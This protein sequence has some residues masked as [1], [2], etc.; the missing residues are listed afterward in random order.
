MNEKND[1]HEK[2]TPLVP[3][4]DFAY[5]QALARRHMEEEAACAQALHDD[6]DARKKAAREEAAA[7]QK[8]LA[9]EKI[10]LMKLKQGVIEEDEAE[11][12]REAP[13]EPLKKMNKRQ[14]LA[15]FWYHHKVITLVI[16]LFGGLIGY[17]V[18]DTA[19]KVEPDLKI[20]VTTDNGLGLRLDDLEAFFTPYATD[21]NGDGKVVV[22]A[23]N[24]P[25]NPRL[26]ANTYQTNS[27]KLS[28]LIMSGDAVL[29]LTDPL[30]DD[31]LVSSLD[32]LT[33]R[34]PQNP[35]IT[36]EGLKFDCPMLREKLNW[37]EMPA[38]MVLGM[39]KVSA[40]L[41]TDEKELN[42]KYEQGMDVFEKVQAD[43]L[44]NAQNAQ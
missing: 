33:V 17:F 35:M 1:P 4:E 25:V 43:I 20:I 37:A 28:T 15:N 7:R 10:E 36:A 13:D 27:T 19:T 32:D 39:R 11:L 8:Q 40:T 12:V 31:L 38:D 34:F 29:F 5:E 18:Y 16:V 6:A 14:Q 22:A 41:M 24:V 42:E 30:T 9:Q 23:Y 3:E 44:E 21:L 2:T 26:D